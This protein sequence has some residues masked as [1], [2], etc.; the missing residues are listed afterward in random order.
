LADVHVFGGNSSPLF[1][2]LGGMRSIGAF[3]G[4]KYNFLGVVSGFYHEDSDFKLSIST[5][6]TGRVAQNSGIAMI[7]PA[8]ELKSLLD[9]S[10]LQAA[11]DA[12][13]AAKKP[14]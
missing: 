11:R 4:I 9:S 13:L 10:P 3:S 8:D 12:E 14:K 2:N 5:T 7:V 6:L 1:V